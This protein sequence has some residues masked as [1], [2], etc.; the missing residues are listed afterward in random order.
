MAIL[1]TPNE[2]GRIIYNSFISQSILTGILD[3]DDLEQHTRDTYIRAG[4]A[5]AERM[6]QWFQEAYNL[7]YGGL[8]PIEQVILVDLSSNHQDSDL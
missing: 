5:V 8:Q 1:P 6:A 4:V 2:L 7:D 3:W